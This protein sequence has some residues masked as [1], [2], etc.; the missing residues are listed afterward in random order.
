M[1]LGITCA[2]ILGNFSD[3]SGY[4]FAITI[5]MLKNTIDT[6][7]LQGKAALTRG[8]EVSTELTM[9]RASSHRNSKPDEKG[10]DNIKLIS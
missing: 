8:I 6:M 5:P 4:N 3:T 10:I 2:D 1:L 7:M 9:S